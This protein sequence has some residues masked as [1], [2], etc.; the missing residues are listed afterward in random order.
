MWSY[1]RVCSCSLLESLVGNKGKLWAPQD[2]PGSSGPV[3]SVIS[4]TAILPSNTSGSPI[5]NEL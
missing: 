2:A 5:C 4:A 1:L 3:D